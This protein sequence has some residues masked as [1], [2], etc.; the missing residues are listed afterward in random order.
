MTLQLW[1]QGQPKVVGNL[2][3]KDEWATRDISATLPFC[4]PSLVQGMTSPSR[5]GCEHP[6]ARCWLD[7][8]S[9]N[10]HW[11]TVITCLEYRWLD[12]SAVTTYWQPPE[13]LSKCSLIA[14]TKLCIREKKK[15]WNKLRFPF[16]RKM[17]PSCKTEKNEVSKKYFTCINMIAF[18]V[19]SSSK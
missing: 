2:S 3:E 18:P 13:S 6:C 19:R 14:P 5:L 8:Q 10:D 15:E 1:G 16:F 7:L 11:I 12:T 9:H 17:Q 4:W